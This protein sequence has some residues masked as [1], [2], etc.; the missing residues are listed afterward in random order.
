MLIQRIYRAAAVSLRSFTDKSEMD[1]HIQAHVLAAGRKLH[2][3][4]RTILDILA[5]HAVCVVGVSWRNET[6]LAKEIGIHRTTVNRAIDR[7]EEL[8][9]GRR[10]SVSLNGMELRYFVFN[11]FDMQSFCSDIATDLHNEE[12]AENIDVSTDTNTFSVSEAIETP[13]LKETDTDDDDLETVFNRIAD[14]EKLPADERQSVLDRIKKYIASV[15][16]IAAYVKSTIK[17][18]AISRQCRSSASRKHSTGNVPFYPQKEAH[19]ARERVKSDV[20]PDWAIKQRDEQRERDR[21]DVE[22]ASQMTKEEYAKKR[23][24]VIG[25][26]RQLSR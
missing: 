11:R 19:A 3:N 2:K 9:I 17:R 18:A 25:M 1:E 4:A 15:G 12:S 6:K 22:K 16:N 20:L 23:T 14:E 8:G 5:R 21:I 26:L 7:L 10:I 24:R 13:E